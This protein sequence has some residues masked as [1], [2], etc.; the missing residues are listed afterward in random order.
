MI[1]VCLSDV[2]RFAGDTFRVK[3]KYFL[4][5]CGLRPDFPSIFNQE[6]LYFG[7]LNQFCDVY[8]EKSNE[9]YFEKKIGPKSQTY[10]SFN[11]ICKQPQNFA[12]LHKI[13]FNALQGIFV[14]AWCCDEVKNFIQRQ[15]HF[16]RVHCPI[17]SFDCFD[18]RS[19][20]ADYVQAR[21]A[22][23]KST[24]N[25]VNTSLI[26]DLPKGR[27][28]K[29]FQPFGPL[30]VCYSPNGLKLNDSYIPKKWDVFFSGRLRNKNHPERSESVQYFA[31]QFKKNKIFGVSDQK[32]F[33]TREKYE[34]L[35]DESV[36]NLVPSGVRWDSFKFGELSIRRQSVLVHPKPWIE[37]CTQEF[38][39]F[40]DS[41]HYDY[42]LINGKY[43]FDAQG[44]D[45]K[46]ALEFMKSVANKE[47]DMSVHCRPIINNMCESN[48]NYHTSLSRSE[49]AF[50]V[51][52][53]IA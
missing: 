18:F 19:H 6:I 42:R 29:L 36:F 17:I 34:Q 38:V 46:K 49:Y 16:G 32:E 33:P 47:T 43:H 1:L 35:S 23:A 39:N 51:M 44:Q 5:S 31:K 20:E 10:P 28:N 25:S 14:S 4:R 15:I 24:L 11:N 22:K 2:R 7:F 37:F 27:A 41:I 3:A 13:D 8:F 30:P 40:H 45:T 9:I 26:V 48:L 50:K 21:L 52:E 12:E 53:S